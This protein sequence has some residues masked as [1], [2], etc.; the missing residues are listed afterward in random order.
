[1][2]TAE[3]ELVWSINARIFYFGQRRWIFDVPIEDDVDEMIRLTIEHFM[4]GAKVVLPQIVLP[5]KSPQKHLRKSK[6]S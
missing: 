3:I 2:K 4:A 1:L 6:K 5:A